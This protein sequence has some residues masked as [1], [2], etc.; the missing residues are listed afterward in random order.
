MGRLIKHGKY[1]KKFKNYCKKCHKR[2]SP[3]SI[4]CAKHKKIAI[5]WKHKKS[6]IEQL[7]KEKIEYY[8]IHKHPC[9]GRILSTKQ[10]KKISKKLTEFYEIHPN[11]KKKLSNIRK[12]LFK[13]L[14]KKEIKEKFYSYIIVKHHLN[15]NRKDN[16]N[17]NIW[18]LHKNL[19]RKLHLRAYDY[20]VKLGLINNYIKWFKNKYK[21]EI[22]KLEIK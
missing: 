10:K 14:S 12:N 5:G 8:K 20:L 2:I 11:H 9:T 6:T 17:N 15:L 21:E 3:F 19:H 22:K 4:Y 1:S 16:Q 13:N 7:S 18:K